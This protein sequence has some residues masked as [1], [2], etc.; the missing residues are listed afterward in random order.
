[1]EQFN[2]EGLTN[3]LA[4]ELLTALET[5]LALWY[6]AWGR[7]DCE[8]WLE[9]PPAQPCFAARSMAAYAKLLLPQS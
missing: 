4:G 2:L 8:Q 5:L 7:A 3:D 9:C 1:M 6:D